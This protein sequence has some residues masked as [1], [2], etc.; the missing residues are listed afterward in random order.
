L[1]K[2]P[3]LRERPRALLDLLAELRLG[4]IDRI[5]EMDDEEL[6]RRFLRGDLGR[7]FT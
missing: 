4:T 5:L 2:L 1:P 6:G 3:E 7:P